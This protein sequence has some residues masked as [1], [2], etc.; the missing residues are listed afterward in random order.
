MALAPCSSRGREARSRA[1]RARDGG[2]FFPFERRGRRG[3][4]SGVP[5]SAGLGSRQSENPPGR[6][7]GQLA[8]LARPCLCPSVAGLNCYD[9]ASHTERRECRRSRGKDFSPVSHREPSG[10]ARTWIQHFCSTRR[11]RAAEKGEARLS[12]SGAVALR[13]E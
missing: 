9:Q 3:S 1:R 10:S 5:A 13:P 8:G 11:R 4:R 2:D 12:K 7:L 6:P